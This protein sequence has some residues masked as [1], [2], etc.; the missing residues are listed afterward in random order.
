MDVREGGLL[1]ELHVGPVEAEKMKTMA[2]VLRDPN[3]I[4]WDVGLVKELGLGTAPVNQGPVNMAYVMNA[5]VAWTGDA[6]ALRSLRIRFLGNVFAGDRLVVGGR[7]TALRS[8]ADAQV[9]DCDVWLDRIDGQRVL[10]GA[11]TVVSG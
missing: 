5:I 4:H 10:S 3:P 11:A 1:P 9:A 6:T 7:V 8:E 2:M